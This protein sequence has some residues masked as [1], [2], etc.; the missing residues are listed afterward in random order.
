MS[1]HVSCL[2]LPS[3]TDT[4]LLMFWTACRTCH[5]VDRDD[6]SAHG[7]RVTASGMMPSD[8]SSQ[9]ELVVVAHLQPQHQGGRGSG[10]QGQPWL[11]GLLSKFKT[12]H[13][14]DGEWISTHTVA[15]ASLTPVPGVGQ[16]LLTC[17]NQAHVCYTYRQTKCSCS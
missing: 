11:P 10:V 9:M 2:C 5:L 14:V 3:L 7:S 4:P 15:Q 16:P 17:V 13:N 8:L 1:V 6:V 12:N